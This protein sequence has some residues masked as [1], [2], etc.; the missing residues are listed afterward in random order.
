MV[1]CKF[2]VYRQV[3]RPFH[4]TRN[5]DNEAQ[6]VRCFFQAFWTFWVHKILHLGDYC[7]LRLDQIFHTFFQLYLIYLTYL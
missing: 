1:R 5:K 4:A 2:I 7:V 6:L 3:T